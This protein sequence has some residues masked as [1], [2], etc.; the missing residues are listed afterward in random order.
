MYDFDEAQLLTLDEMVLAFRS[1]LA[2]LSKLS[3]INPPTE[4]EVEIIVVQGFD[5]MR[6]VS[7]SVDVDTDF[8]GMDKE[9]FISFCLNTP[10]IMSW[11]EYFDDLE[12]YEMDMNN[13]D[14]VPIPEP[15]H[16]DRT[17]TDESVMNPTLGGF[18]RRNWERRGFAKDILPRL[19][20][21]NVIQYIAP[22]RLPDQPRDVPPQNISLDWI[23]GYNAHSSKQNCYYSAKGF[24]V[25]PAG[26]ACIVQDVSNKSQTYFLCHTDIVTCL[27]LYHTSQ[28]KTI[29]ATG[30][31]GYRPS[32][33]IW[34][35]DSKELIST[36][37]GF[38]RRG[39]S[40]LDFS[41][42]RTKLAA[43]GCDTYNSIAVYKWQTRELIFASRTT[44]EAVNDIRFL[45][46]D[47]IAS[48]GKDHV[49]F[50]KEVKTGVYKRYRGLFGTA[51]RPEILTCVNIVGSTIVTGSITGMIHVWEGRNLVSSIK[52]H[53]GSIH[54][55]YVVDQ[56]DKQG[57]ITACSTGK[58]QIWN[59]KLEV[60]V[61]FN[62]YSLGSIEPAITSIC[63][64]VLVN[65]IL[66][67]FKC[68][69]IFEM[70]AI[71]GRNVHNSSVVA[72]NSNP[73]VGGIATHP[74]NPN[75][76]CTVGN[77]KTVR[78]FDAELH[79]QLR[80]TLLDTIGNCVAFSPDGQMLL[81]GLGSGIEGNE[82]RKEGAYVVLNE[83]DLTLVHEARDSK[84]Q[85]TDCKFS[86]P[87][88]LIALSSL[89]GSIYVY[90]ARDFAAKSRC[91]G[92]VGKVKHIDFSHDG[93]FLMSNCSA[94][95]LLFWDVERGEIQL[96]KTVKEVQWETN[97][98]VYSYATQG[99][100][101]PYDDGS[102]VSSV[103]RSHARDLIAAVD[104][105]GRLRVYVC[106]VIKE[107]PNYILCNF[108]TSN[109][110]KCTFSCDDSYLF[111]SGGTDGCIAQW[112]CVLPEVQ[113]TEEMKK[114]ESVK[115]V[116]PI[117]IGFEGR[118]LER[119]DYCEN[120]LND[121]YDSVFAMEEGVD[122]GAQ[123]QPW[124]RTITAPS[125]VPQEDL[126]EPPDALD[127]AFVYGF[128]SDRS[129]ESILYTQNGELLFF[130]AS[131][132]VIMNQQKR[133]QRYYRDH[134]STI[135]SIATQKNGPYVAS[136]DQGEV[137][138]I[139]VWHSE[140]FETL[141]VIQGF[142]RRGVNHLKFSS[143]GELLV[144]VGQ[145]RFHSIAVYNWKCGQIISYTTSIQ[146]KCFFIDFIPSGKGLVQCGNEVIRFWEINGRNLVFQDALLGSRAKLQG[147]MCVGWI[148]SIPI[149]GT[150]DG[151]L[152][153][154]SG[155]QLDAMIQA[156]SGCINSIASTNEGVCSA[157]VDG[158]VKIWTRTLECRLVID[159]K[160]L[161][162]INSVARCVA[163]E[164][165]YGRVAIGTASS[166][167][168]E[169]GAGDGE[170][171]HPSALLEGHGGFELWGLSV[172]PTREEF[173]STGDDAL[174][175]VWD[176]FS[177]SAVATVPLEMP[178]RCCAFSPDGKQLAVGF[179]CPQ[180]LSAKQYDGKWV[181]LDTDDYQVSHEARDSTKWLTEIKYSPSGEVIVIGSYDNKIYVY[182]VP[183]GYALL[184]TISQH[185]SF[186]KSIDIS[187]DNA[188]IQSNCGGFELCYF[189]TDTGMFIPAA[190]RLRDMAWSTQNCTMAWAVQGIWPPQKDGTECTA[191]ECNLFRGSDG[192]IVASGDNYGRIQLFRYPC[193]SSF[194]VSKKYRVSSNPI[195]RMR[196]ASGDSFL[197]SLSG[198]D[199]TIIQFN[200]KRDRN[201]DVA[202]NVNER[203]GAIEEE[204]D[205]IL[206]YF[207][208]A[209]VD[210]ELPDMKELNNMVTSKP[211]VASIVAP[212]N[213]KESIDTPPNYRL[214]K[215]HIFGLQT[216]L[217]RSSI[218][219]NCCGDILYPASHYVCVYNK[220]KNEQIYYEGHMNEISCV[221]ISKN[222][223]IAAS[224]E[225]STRCSIHIWDAVTT[226]LLI[227]FYP[228]HRRGVSSI[229]FSNSGK[230]MVSVGQD[231][232]NSIAVWEST[233]GSWADGT[234]LASAKG[235][236]NPCLFCSF[237]E[238]IPGGYFLASGGRFHQ[239]FWNI[240]G[241]CL[242]AN[243]AIYEAKQKI[244]TLLC[245]TTVG[246][247]FVSGSTS[248]HLF[249][250]SGRKLDRMIR[251]HEL[252]VTC[253]WSCDKGMITTS[254]D[255]MIKLWSLD[256]EHI[257]SFSLSDADIPP[258][259]VSIRSLHG[260]LST[261][262][263]TITRILVGTAGGETY[264]IAAR[265]GNICLVHEGHF[266]GELWGLTTHPTNSD[267][268]A[269][270]GDDKTIRVWSLSHRRL[271][272]KAV[273][274]STARSIDWSKD[275]RNIIVGL[276]GSGDGKRQRKDGAFLILD[277]ENLRPL[278]EGRDSRHWLQ[279]VKFSPDGRAFAVAS[280][281][282]KIYIYSRETFRLKGTC[283]RHNS[284]IKY[285]DFSEDSVY[286]QSDSGDHEHLYFEA[287]DGEYFATGSQLKDIHWNDWTC[288]YGWPVQ[289]TW[290]Y[291]D[292]VDKG[293]AFDPTS[294]HRSP[295]E[296]LLAVGDL[297]G[298]IKLYNYPCLNKAA[299]SVK[300]PAHVKEVS[301]VRF[302][303]DGKHIISLGKHDRAI[304][305]WKVLPEKSKYF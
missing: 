91:R 140:T 234:L 105:Y 303:C 157:S 254:K 55:C 224:A 273:L 297:G 89:D 187:E 18:E 186:I 252:G 257:R 82:E 219:F 111:T 122:G 251:A 129:R 300:Q 256:L 232:D 38:F 79:K 3:K 33:H 253:I 17:I 22:V 200:H 96:P 28:G 189:E 283:D 7:N 34:D 53:P 171:M 42:D 100:W 24:V 21:Q 223:M 240:D 75:M 248:G 174:L 13:R 76:F 40:Q 290:P 137:P 124:Q 11:I 114:D 301:K 74:M 8:P 229:Q 213:A 68:C 161:R 281:D 195:T 145:D 9:S 131:M 63:W 167:I 121:R 274:D 170:N 270:V 103:S 245:G 10:E 64:D 184:A 77:D 247:K 67:G 149:V 43:I 202:F 147:F 206:K 120:V 83:E 1:T 133:T 211:W 255:G 132:I 298:N 196:F 209:G 58:I 228:F 265:S 20:Y 57:L 188:W 101:G 291:F 78:I 39:I 2:G 263:S 104:N 60:G 71:D 173:C 294:V 233:S 123:M 296:S 193:T 222:G 4:S 169:V 249:V 261:D 235:D 109:A 134:S 115:D 47:L 16:K 275:G 45:S 127:V 305:I 178:S 97:T 81:V 146:P 27:K 264:E 31:C 293:L 164:A 119:P 19:N 12:E 272:R 182:N 268:F 65:K 175:R 205:D 287:E 35:C 37:R 185:Q 144:T 220:K 154:F 49:Y 61:L 54:A 230:Y 151:Y 201:P 260:G 143:D 125:R 66:V 282:H 90:N 44:F 288:V 136:G 276:G 26:S 32:I 236:V 192:T 142:H 166:E 69:E 168:F 148:G 244:G 221:G 191:C 15:T 218:V 203:R 207:D 250:W 242:N 41:Q 88:D 277:A 295:D 14:P 302:S 80:V 198:V 108:H 267:V 116:M 208:L 93:Q 163:W 284:F 135:M 51:V 56:G 199:K 227:K 212:T 72:G 138:M 241:K 107:D 183:Q 92:H 102:Q 162:A 84:N 95:E 85:I 271:L 259:M 126:S 25:Y 280:M 52:G 73:R 150:A 214:E 292:E 160:A 181:V 59:Y 94:G 217:T 258:V 279:D 179:G 239:K 165:N 278:Y 117:E 6:K 225:R 226:Q 118:A 62:G 128:T 110:R 50:W 237:Y 231:Q 197:L 155:R 210:E 204:E 153:R 99:V 304:V 216:T 180:K 176:L 238:E 285:F 86:P 246:H 194:A 36:L 139:R 286:I 112:K 141:S 158:F 262:N 30:E 243:Y 156:H 177:H 113:D 289:G 215:S 299:Q 172:N 190:S 87:G 98:C 5:S 159:V 269:T 130:A 23:Y 46:D 48:C 70:D 106:P 152:Y 266:T 29:V